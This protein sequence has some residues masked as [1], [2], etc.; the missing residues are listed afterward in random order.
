MI[1][2]KCMLLFLLFRLVRT[3]KG[4][5]RFTNLFI[6]LHNGKD[7]CYPKVKNQ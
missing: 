4:Y 2:W 5:W 7:Y 1:C 6:A 3:N